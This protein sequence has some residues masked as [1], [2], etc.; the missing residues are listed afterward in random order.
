MPGI[1]TVRL[2]QRDRAIRIRS[3]MMGAKLKTTLS[4]YA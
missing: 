4:S 3:N 2:V 1:I